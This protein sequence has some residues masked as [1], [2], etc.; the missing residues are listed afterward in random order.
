MLKNGAL[1]VKIGLDTADILLFWIETYFDILVVF[2]YF[3]PLPNRNTSWNILTWKYAARH[4]VVAGRGD[5]RHGE[6]HGG[7]AR[8]E[9]ELA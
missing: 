3:T 2:W 5:D 8:R 7:H 1:V 9:V 4:G 6:A